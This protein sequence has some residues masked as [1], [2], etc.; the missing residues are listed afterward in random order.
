MTEQAPEY[1]ALE[2]AIEHANSTLDWIE[3]RD[4][5]L[6]GGGYAR[7]ECYV[8]VVRALRGVT[9]AAEGDGA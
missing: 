3:K 5:P 8:W 2:R 9:I 6:P 7:I 1:T 4:G